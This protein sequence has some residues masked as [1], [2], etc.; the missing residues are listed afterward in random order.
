MKIEDLINTLERKKRESCYSQRLSALQK[1]GRDTSLI[2]EGMA[3]T[4][5][6]LQS[7]AKSFVIYGEPQ[8][9]KT[10][11]M[12]ALVCK[13]IDMGKQTIFIV[14][15]DNTELENQNFD[16]FH[17]ASELNPTPMRDYELKDLS[18]ADLK[19]KRQRIIFCRKNSKN[20]QKLIELT[21]WMDDRVIIDDEADY[22]SPNAKINK[23]DITAIN[24]FLGELG[25]FSREDCG[26]YI[27]VTATPAR[28]NL[29]NTFANDA[30][31]WVFLNSHGQYKGHNFFFPLTRSDVTNSDYNL[32]RLPDETDN[33]RLLRA[34]VFRFMI[35]VALLNL[36][37][38][39]EIT[40]YSMLIHTAGKTN[41][42]ETDQTQ[43]NKILSTLSDSNS[44]KYRQYAEEL[45]KI[46]KNIVRDSNADFLPEELWTFVMQ[47]IGKKD[48][49]VINHKNDSGNV[50]RAGQPKAL[51]TFA[52][53]GNIVSRGLTFEN[54]L[55]F[56]FSRNVKNKLQ[57]NT[58][59]QR[60]RMFGWRPYSKHFELC[61]PETLFKNWAECFH[62]HEVSL[63]LAKA[64]EYLHIYGSKTQV[65]DAGAIDKLNISHQNSER[66]IGEIFP[67][68]PQLE[69]ALINF[70]LDDPIR[71]IEKLIDEGL[72]PQSAIAP[73]LR[74]YF[75]ELA[76]EETNQFFIVLKSG[77]DG[78]E[79]QTIENYKDGDQESIQRARGGI[80]HAMLNN[81]VEYDLY[82][83]F[84]LP[85]KNNDG[86]ARIIYK[87]KFKKSIMQNIK[88][89]SAAI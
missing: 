4:I 61:V 80:I 89:Q 45:F 58:Y 13:L 82:Q 8:S 1:R 16:R 57:Q 26:I 87:P 34:A 21:R 35:R 27:G 36:H 74:M 88:L 29:N 60:A 38:Q 12:I 64:G 49:L 52:I 39:S 37:P 73:A 40:P 79:I 50:K 6:T 23:Q 46:S 63:R 68:T 42:H 11:F 59:I 53:G 81:R 76:S 3:D 28:L 32:V 17:A 75:R 70:N 65:V 18:N 22:A 2:E 31:K 51:F 19:I 83:H 20:L 71:H 66:N 56:Y 47:N 15:N 14:M 25:K 72:L 62:D 55:T 43:I 9:G 78:N 24:K 86:N 77:N 85:I 30:S 10:E 7:G 41:D 69:S 48:V 33:P 44:S 67:L 54:L 5:Q 84:I